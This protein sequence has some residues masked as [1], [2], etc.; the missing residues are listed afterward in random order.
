M[1]LLYL[2]IVQLCM[3]S[4]KSRLFLGLFNPERALSIAHGRR[5]RYVNGALWLI[6][7]RQTRV[8]G[9]S[10]FW[11]TLSAKFLLEGFVFRG[12]VAA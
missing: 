7:V 6:R 11:S 4:Q 2:F 1:V 10:G 12:A 8:A 9:L 5:F 3:I